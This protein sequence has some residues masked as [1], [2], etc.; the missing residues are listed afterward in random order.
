MGSVS[1]FVHVPYK[2]TAWS[3]GALWP[4]GSRESAIGT[5]PTFYN[6]SSAQSG[7]SGGTRQVRGSQAGVC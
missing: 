1:E 4:L 6:K 7:D 3:E 5:G 2:G